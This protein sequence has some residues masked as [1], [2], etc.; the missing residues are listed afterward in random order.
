MAVMHAFD[1]ARLS[2]SS[3]ILSIVFVN[4][5]GAQATDVQCA[6]CVDPSDLASKSVTSGKL[7]NSAVTTDKIAAGAITVNKIAD[8]AVSRSKLRAGAV[9][10]GKIQDSAVT[11]AKIAPD[12]VGMSQI[13]PSQV[14]ARVTGQ[15]PS[16]Q[17][18]RGVNEDGSVVC[19]PSTFRAVAFYDRIG[20]VPAYTRGFASITTPNTGIYCLVPSQGSGIDPTTDISLV[21]VEFG[22]SQGADLLVFAYNGQCNAGEFGVRTYDFN[23]GV[24]LTDDVAFFIAV[25]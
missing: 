14:Q 16:G 6:Q 20:L 15:C 4:T 18:V 13:D 23:S 9:S 24:V 3:L 5:A 1:I 12:A 8:T 7:G 17:D 11:G 25:P 21:S 22:E 19:A 10:T 2:I